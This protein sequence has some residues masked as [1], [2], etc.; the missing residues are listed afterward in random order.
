M[1]TPLL[2]RAQ[3]LKLFR[4]CLWPFRK[5]YRSYREF[6]NYHVAAGIQG[7]VQNLALRY[8]VIRIE[9]ILAVMRRTHEGPV[10]IR[11][12]R[13]GTTFFLSALNCSV[14]AAAKEARAHRASPAKAASAWP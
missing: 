2:M 10:H 13:S 4:I 12:A 9:Q 5:G 7:G 11:Y 6:G 14:L 8:V 3:N 1:G